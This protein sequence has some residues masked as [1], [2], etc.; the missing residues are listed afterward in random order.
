MVFLNESHVCLCYYFTK[1]YICYISGAAKEISKPRTMVMRYYCSF[2]LFRSPQ[3]CAGQPPSRGDLRRADTVHSMMGAGRAA[4]RRWPDDARIGI[5]QHPLRCLRV[6]SVYL[7]PLRWIFL[8]AR[9]SGG[10]WQAAPPPSLSLVPRV[11]RG[12]GAPHS[13]PVNEPLRAHSP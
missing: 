5:S 4:A 3:V 1:I 2:V 10:P 11:G 8:N 6:E 7:R 12:R 9:L 13:L